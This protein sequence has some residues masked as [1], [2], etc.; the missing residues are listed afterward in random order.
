MEY[1]GSILDSDR[2]LNWLED[3]TVPVVYPYGDNEVC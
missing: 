2:L 1:D 3:E